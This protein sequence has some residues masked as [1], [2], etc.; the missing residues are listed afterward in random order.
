MRSPA[1]SRWTT[2]KPLTKRLKPEVDPAWDAAA[3]E[4]HVL[5]LTDAEE[6]DTLTAHLPDGSRHVL[7]MP[8]Q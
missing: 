1:T 2:G 7:R 3:A 4:L 8:E 6:Y 5:I